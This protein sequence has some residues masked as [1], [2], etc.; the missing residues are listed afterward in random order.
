MNCGKTAD[1]SFDL[2]VDNLDV[3]ESTTLGGLLNVEGEASF[4]ENLKLENQTS[5]KTVTISASQL[6]MDYNLNLPPNDGEAGYVLS[7]NGLGDL[8]WMPGSSGGG[9]VSYIGISP[10]NGFMTVNG[11]ASDSTTTNK[12]FNLE[13]S[14]A[15]DVSHGGTGLSSAG[16]V[17]QLLQSTGAGMEWTDSVQLEEVIVNGSFTN[18]GSTTLSGT[19]VI[20]GAVSMGTLGIVPASFISDVVFGPK[21]VLGIIPARPVQLI[22]LASN[23]SRSWTLGYDPVI[24]NTQLTM[25]DTFNPTRKVLVSYDGLRCTRTGAGAVELPRVDVG[26]TTIAGATYCGIDIYTNLA[27]LAGSFSCLETVAFSGR[28]SIYADDTELVGGYLEKNSLVFWEN[29][30]VPSIE[31][32]NEGAFNALNIYAGNVVLTGLAG[33]FYST[34]ATP[35][36]AELAIYADNGLQNGAFMDKNNIALWENGLVP[37]IELNTDGS[38]N[39]L[40]IYGGVVPGASLSGSFYA[41]STT[42]FSG[43]LAIYSDATELNGMFIDNKS[44]S[45]ERNGGKCLQLT[46][47]GSLTGSSTPFPFGYNIMTVFGNSVPAIDIS[48]ANLG[49]FTGKISIYADTSLQTGV[50]IDSNSFLIAETLAKNIEITSAGTFNSLNVYTNGVLAGSFYTTSATNY[51]GE[52][53]IY[54]DSSLQNGA[55]IDKDNISL[56]SNGT[57]P[58][59]DIKRGG[60]LL[61]SNDILLYSGTTLS[62]ALSAA[63]SSTYSGKLSFY[64]DA[65]LINGSVL[66]K[67]SLNFSKSSFGTPQNTLTLQSNNIFNNSPQLTLYTGGNPT[68]VLTNKGCRIVQDFTPLLFLGAG[69]MNTMSGDTGVS[70]EYGALEFFRLGATVLT[71]TSTAFSS[72]SD[73]SMSTAQDLILKS[74]GLDGTG[75]VT[76]EALGVGTAAISIRAAATTNGSITIQAIGTTSTIS[77]LSTTSISLTSTTISLSAGTSS[78]TCGALTLTGGTTAITLGATTM[79]FGVTNITTGAATIS[80]G[81]T[82]LTMGAFTMTSAAAVITTAATTWTSGGLFTLT[83][84]AGGI[85]ITCAGGA[86]ALTTGGGA[87]SITTGA[88]ILTITTGIGLMS[89]IAGLGGINMNCIGGNIDIITTVGGV[90]IS[91][92]SGNSELSSNSGA[93]FI[94]APVGGINVG[95]SGRRNGHF[96]VYCENGLTS[97]GTANVEFHTSSTGLNTG[98]GDFVVNTLSA[99]SGNILFQSKGPF[100]LQSQNALALRTWG[101]AHDL[102][103]DTRALLGGYD[104]IFPSGPGDDGQVLTSKGSGNAQQW[105]SLSSITGT[106]SLT[107]Q[108]SGIL[109]VA[110]GG[111]GSST[112]PL[113]SLTSGVSGILP[114]ANGGTGSATF[115]LIN[116]TSGVSNVLPIANG[117][118]GL[119]NTGSSGQLLTSVRNPATV[120]SGTGSVGTVTVSG[121]TTTYPSGT[122]VL[123]AGFTSTPPINGTQTV[124]GGSGTTITFATSAT[125]ASVLGTVSSLSWGAIDLAVQVSGILPVVNGGTG[126]SSFPLI[127]LTSGVSN[128][129]PVANGILVITKVVRI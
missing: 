27:A 125:T 42:A 50:F 84:A 46:I 18:N 75:S 64:A 70:L 66:D 122:Q 61:G 2:Y 111:T 63:T 126:S 23:F 7:T 77:L 28:L 74:N 37:A 86:I 12:T 13:L 43:E 121:G 24:S 53:A 1:G 34:A 54:A 108:V 94:Y 56:W 67:D 80:L 45:V 105:V 97:P 26:T 59:I 96:Y 106:I 17:R 78:F 115:P 88:G 92:G 99:Y 102:R 38:Y 127:N 81:A 44:L 62:A 14:G 119:V 107:S 72:V 82:I 117:G 98:P 71:F 91:C 109:P 114:I 112:F 22:G 5:L 36:S 10:P 87:C 95:E 103:M 116:L 76:V 25:V 113:I 58:A 4:E 83:N 120:Y 65:A 73:Y 52:F 32:K 3:N 6:M 33:S 124:T 51:S 128:I 68:C 48:A 129:L 60:G 20:N 104:W 30:T 41:T 89:F 110:N 93:V 31:L 123:L 39:A 100:F 19:T 49:E 16:P 85:A 101:G 79:Q 35:Y 47:D 57:N 90:K 11:M 21:P 9:S 55:F 15:L 29:P 118:T 40:N 8:N 69:G